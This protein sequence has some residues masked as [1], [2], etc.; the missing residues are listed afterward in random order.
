MLKNDVRN[1]NE[2]KPIMSNKPL[3]LKEGNSDF[4]ISRM[5]SE[6]NVTT[7]RKI[8]K[9]CKIKGYSKMKKDELES[10][11]GG[12]ICEKERLPESLYLLCHIDIS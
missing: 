4:T 2:R 3:S 7:L 9:S 1:R 11:L 6:K 8:A 5:L 10:C 12:V